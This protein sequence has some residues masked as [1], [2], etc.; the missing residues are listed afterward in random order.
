MGITVLDFLVQSSKGFIQFLAKEDGI[1]AKPI[2]PN[3]FIQNK[4]FA[5]A[6]KEMSFLRFFGEVGDMA[7]ESCVFLLSF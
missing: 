4:P 2:L 5:Y 6:F 1:I 7:N 3:G